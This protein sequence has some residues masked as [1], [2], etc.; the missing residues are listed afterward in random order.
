MTVKGVGI[1]IHSPRINGDLA[2][3]Q[4]DLDYFA[5]CGFDYVEIPAHGVDV[6]V[7]GRLQPQRLRQVK[8][9]LGRFPFSYTVHSPDP[10]NLFDVEH[11]EWHKEVFRSTIAFAQEIGAETVV[12]H[13]GRQ[14]DM[15]G[16]GGLKL[17]ALKAGEREALQEMGDLARRAG[18]MIGVENVGRESYGAVIADLVAQVQAIAHPA[19]GITLDIGHAMLAAPLFGFDLAQAIRLAAPLIVHWHLHDNFGRTADLPHSIPYI[20]AA[21]YGIGDMHM[22]PGWGAIPYEQIL[23]GLRTPPRRAADGD[24]AALSRRFA[25]GARFRASAI[26]AHRG[27]EPLETLSPDILKTWQRRILITSWLTYAGFYLGRVNLAVALPALQNHFGWTRSEAGLIGSA[28][29]W[30]YAI[31][32]LING[33]L[34]DRWNPRYFVAAGLIASALMNLAFGFSN[35]LPLFILIWGANGYVQSTG[36]GPIMRT[37]SNWFPARERGRVTAIFRALLCRRAWSPPGC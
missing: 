6:I 9:I 17:D 33:A 25:G 14:D 13:G 36:W 37:L 2:L 35:A 5:A 21:P 24:S 31:G 23:P 20:A 18:V 12:Y 10:L 19:I 32:Q 29:F 22:P 30:L 27:L 1:D 28:F 26:Q 7:A 34:G 11:L 3:L 16:T 8:Q 15:V 4:H